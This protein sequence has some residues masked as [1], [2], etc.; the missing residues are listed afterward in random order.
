[1]QKVVWRVCAKAGLLLAAACSWAPTFGEEPAGAASRPLSEATVAPNAYFPTYLLTAD[2]GCD[3]E[4]GS[5]PILSDFTNDW[6]SSQ[7]KAAGER[8]LIDDAASAPQKIH[9]RFTWLRSFDRPIVVRIAEQANGQATID[10]KML[11]GDGGYEPG[12]VT[13]HV[14][15]V[16]TSSEW[17][18]FKA[19]LKRSNLQAEAAG[20]C[21]LGLDG[22]QWVLEV[23][24]DG[25]YTF[26]E[27]WSPDEGAVR[28]VALAML[29]LTGFRLNPIY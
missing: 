5:Q 1:M 24:T 12:K 20:N 3:A 26:F 9:L 11:S 21:D 14:S 22:A 2:R 28:D 19:R 16:L 4:F 6:Y 10:A 13:E 23:V 27:R 25:R 29:N 8:S 7:L 15:R 17:A 18:A